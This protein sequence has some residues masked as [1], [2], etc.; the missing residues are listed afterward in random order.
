MSRRTVP[1]VRSSA[2]LGSP[3]PIIFNVGLIVSQPKR[4]DIVRVIHELVGK[5]VY[6]LDHRVRQDG[7]GL[8]DYLTITP[9]QPI[10]HE[11]LHLLVR[12][13][14]ESKCSSTRAWQRSM[15]SAILRQRSSST[16]GWR[17]RSFRVP[18]WRGTGDTRH[19]SRPLPIARLP[20]T[21]AANF[22]KATT[23]GNRARKFAC[24]TFPWRHTSPCFTVAV[25]GERQSP[26]TRDQNARTA[27]AELLQPSRVACSGLLRPS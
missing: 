7:P 10:G 22:P 24:D 1:P 11:T 18:S 14:S 19:C 16:L 5:L 15:I 9:N 17:K 12:R 26:G 13:A 27:A 3:R 4:C 6:S 23:S 8:F 20:P 25:V 21:R 2:A